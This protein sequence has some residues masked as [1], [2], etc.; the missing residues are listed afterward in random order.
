MHT[1]Q[2]RKVQYEHLRQQQ[3]VCRLPVRYNHHW[4]RPNPMQPLVAHT[5]G[6]PRTGAH[7]LPREGALPCLPARAVVPWTL[8]ARRAPRTRIE[9]VHCHVRSR[10]SG[11]GGRAHA[12]GTQGHGE[13]GPIPAGAAGQSGTNARPRARGGGTAR[14]RCARQQWEAD[15]VS[16]AAVRG[17]QLVGCD[18]ERALRRDQQGAGDVNCTG[19]RALDQGDA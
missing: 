14:P 3:G 19:H 9:D 16:R 8:R 11:G 12:G 17:S 7:C 1:L 13:R 10:P 2:P 6:S 4:P 18:P 15:H 5:T